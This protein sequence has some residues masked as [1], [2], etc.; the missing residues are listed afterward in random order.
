MKGFKNSTR[1]QYS[2]GGDVRMQGKT[3]PTKGPMKPITPPTKGP[4]KPIT[5]PT[6]EPRVSVEPRPAMKKGG[7]V[8]KKAGGGPVQQGAATTQA[9]RPG[10]T[11]A[12]TATTPRP[13]TTTAASTATAPR[14]GTTASSNPRGGLLDVVKNPSNLF[15]QTNRTLSA[16]RDRIAAA[17]SRAQQTLAQVKAAK[18][19]EQPTV[20]KA[21]G[22]LAAMPK[23]KC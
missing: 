1:T 7:G 9:S 21:M 17:A 23:G 8:Q 15:T 12:S 22:G 16:G 11:A 18:A 20:K 4:M 13:A 2:M 10:T 14:P 5:P 6:M 3:P 19:R